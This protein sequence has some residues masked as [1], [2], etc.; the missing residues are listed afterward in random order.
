MLK[1]ILFSFTLTPACRNAPF[2][3]FVL[4]SKQASTYR[5]G[6]ERVLARLGGR[7]KKVR[8]GF[9][10][11]LGPRWMAILSIL[12]VRGNHWESCIDASQGW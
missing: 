9:F 2:L 10:L 11:H 12:L 4:G 1:K 7:V 3:S 5:I 6:K 8:L